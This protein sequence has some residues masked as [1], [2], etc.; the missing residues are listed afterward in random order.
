MRDIIGRQSRPKPPMP[1]NAATRGGEADIIASNKETKESTKG[2]WVGKKE[3][4]S[5]AVS[6]G[7]VREPKDLKGDT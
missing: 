2:G 7:G 3:R 5:V 4:E 1:Q 6:D